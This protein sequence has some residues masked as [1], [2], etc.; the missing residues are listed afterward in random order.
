MSTLDLP[1]GGLAPYTENELNRRRV[2]RICG[3]WQVYRLHANTNLGQHYL[4]ASL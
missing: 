4:L 1:K 3:V 2:C